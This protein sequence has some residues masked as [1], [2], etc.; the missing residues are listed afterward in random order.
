MWS[1]LDT[2][3]QIG[4]GY[5]F[6]FALALAGPNWWRGALA[7]ILLV[8]WLAFAAY[9]V[10]GPTYDFS[11]VGVTPEWLQQYGFSGWRSHW[12][13]NAN[14]AFAFDAWFLPLFP[15]NTGNFAPKGLTTLNFVPTIGT[16]ILGLSAG[17]ALAIPGPAA[18]RLRRLFVAGVAGAI[19][20]LVL[21][22]TGLCPIV[23]SIWTPSWV[24]FSGGLSFFFVA[25]FHWLVD[26]HGFRR[27]A[28]VLIVVGS[29]SMVAYLLTHLYPAFA[30]GTLQ[31]L[32]GDAPFAVLGP[33]YQPLIYGMSVILMYWLVLYAMYRAGWHLRV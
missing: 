2:L 23:K 11:A 15:G 14:V 10:A 20:G 31:R 28:F 3:S 7:V 8:V 17:Q 29:N 33:T 9:P 27:A 16:M 21:D 12:Q 30:W 6:V 4:L 5:A 25:V 18:P 1:F 32:F 19:S 26:I 24:L 22:E 13:K